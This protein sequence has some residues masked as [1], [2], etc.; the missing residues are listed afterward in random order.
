MTAVQTD[1]SFNAKLSAYILPATLAIC[2]FFAQQ[3]Y[4]QITDQLTRI[5]Q[6][7]GSDMIQI[8]EIKLRLLQLEQMKKVEA[9]EVRR[10]VEKLP[11]AGPQ[12]AAYVYSQS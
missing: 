9:P 11:K 3:S 6:R 5:E 8:A 1:D 10:Q 2:A 7:Q 12:M 4:K